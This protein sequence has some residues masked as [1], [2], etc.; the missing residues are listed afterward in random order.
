MLSNYPITK[1]LTLHISLPSTLRI[2]GIIELEGISVLIYG[3]Q[4][5]TGKILET[6]QLPVLST[7][8][9]GLS[10]VPVRFSKNSILASGPTMYWVLSTERRSPKTKPPSDSGSGRLA[11][12]L[13][14]LPSQ[15]WVGMSVSGITVHGVG[16]HTSNERELLTFRL[17]PDFQSGHN[18]DQEEWIWLSATPYASFTFAK[19]HLP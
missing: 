7:R 6:K 17:S 3:L 1:L 13:A 11:K 10:P 5:L 15:K 14:Y 12:L 19:G 2:L 9:P 18:Y 16:E 8:T 4:Q